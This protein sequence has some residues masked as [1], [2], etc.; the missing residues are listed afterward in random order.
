[1]PFSHYSANLLSDTYNSYI[2][3]VYDIKNTLE[4][5]RT[6]PILVKYSLIN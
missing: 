6:T 3:I 5:L 4:H 2:D 1:M